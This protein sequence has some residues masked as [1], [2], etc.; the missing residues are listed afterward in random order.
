MKKII[1]M[2]LA[3]ML[4][5][6]TSWGMLIDD[7][8]TISNTTVIDF[9]EWTGSEGSLNNTFQ[10]GSFPGDVEWDVS[11]SFDSG[12]I[13]NGITYLGPNGFWDGRD[14]YPERNGYTNLNDLTGDMFYSFETPVSFVGGFINY[15]P[16]YEYGHPTIATLD[17]N[18]NVI[19]SYLLS[20]D[21]QGLGFNAG[22]YWGISSSTNDIYSLMVSN[23]F[24]VLDDLTYSR[25]TGNV[26]PVPEPATILLMGVGLAGIAAVQRK[27]MKNDKKND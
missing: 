15:D 12:I 10:I 17:I 21:V 20:I 9:H 6:G 26:A 5:T 13:G 14:D 3:L 23:A 8:S 25:D 7:F 11:S 24:I 1:G 22:E 27:R 19:E 16:D 2:F 4:L 18:D